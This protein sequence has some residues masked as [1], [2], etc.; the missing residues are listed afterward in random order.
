MADLT[1]SV[2]SMTQYYASDSASTSG[3]GSGNGTSSSIAATNA[4]NNAKSN[5]STPGGGTP[6]NGAGSSRSGSSYQYFGTTYGDVTTSTS[7]TSTSFNQASTPPYSAKAKCV[8]SR[9]SYIYQLKLNFTIPSDLTV[10]LI[11][12]AT[13]KITG[14]STQGNDKFRVIAPASSTEQTSYQKY[15]N[16]TILSNSIYEEA[17][18]SGSSATNYEIDVK[19]ILI[20]CINTGSSW[21]TLAIPE[22]KV[23]GDAHI[24]ITGTPIIEVNY[25]YTKCGAPTS[26]TFTQVVKPSGTLTISWS[27]ATSGIN[28]AISGY[29]VYYK[30]GSAPTTSSYDGT[31]SI[32]T[33]ATSG[34]KNFTISSTATRGSTFYAMVQTKGSSAAG[35]SFYS[36]WKSASGGK[37]NSLP[38]APLVS[39]D[40]GRIKSSG[41]TTITFTVT[42]GADNDSTQT[43]TLY[44]ATS[45]S[46]TKTSFT[47]PKSFTISTATT[48]YFWTYDGLEY[49]SSYTSKAITVNTAP[50]ITSVTMS[51]YNDITYTPSVRNGYVTNINGSAVVT[52][53][54]N[55]TLTYQWKLEVGS[56]VSAT[57]FDTST[58]IDTTASLSEID[59]TQYGANFNTAYRL[60]LKI[61]DDIGEFA[62]LRSTNV[63]AIPA[64]PTINTYNRKNDSNCSNTNN[65]HFEDGIRVIYGNSE[66]INT[67][68]IKQLLYSTSSDF[69][70]NSTE[71][72]NL[73]GDWWQDID[74]SSLSRGTPSYYFKVKYTC[75]SISADATSYTQGSTTLSTPYFVYTRALDLAPTITA[76]TQQ[77]GDII[78]PYTQSLINLTF[79]HGSNLSS[80]TANNDVRPYNSSNVKPT[81]IYSVK[82]IYGDNEISVPLGNNFSISSGIV[83]GSLD[84]GSMLSTSWKTL[85]GSSTSPNGTYSIT[86]KLIT[87]NSFGKSFNSTKS[88]NVSFIEGFIN[89]G[90]IAVILSMETADTPSYTNINTTTYTSSNR[91]PLFET[92]KLR[93]TISGVKAYAEQNIRINIRKTN[94]SGDILVYNNN[95]TASD[96]TSDNSSRTVWTLNTT[97]IIYT[98]PSITESA[99]AKFYIE[100]ILDN[101]QT[102]SLT[103]DICRYRRIQIS[104]IKPT[105]TEVTETANNSNIFTFNYQITDCGG[106]GSNNKQS[107][108]SSVKGRFLKCATINGSYTNVGSTNF[109]IG[110]STSEQEQ[111]NINDT[112]SPLNTDIIYFGIQ[113]NLIVDF[114]APNGSSPLPTGTSS[115]SIIFINLTTLYRAV[116][117][118]GY[119][120]NFFF[121]NQNNPKSG[122]TD[123]L[124]EIS[125]TNTRTKIYFGQQNDI[126]YFEIDEVNGDLKINCG[127]WS[128]S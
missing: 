24:D 78:K 125:P 102:T 99:D 85:I 23:T 61:T 101:G 45:A 116:P 49:S 72:I 17:V 69:P 36:D 96:W 95:L 77:S 43:K 54:S 40:K 108:F 62:E 84:I 14:T 67:G 28:N 120:K 118:L 38:N 89:S 11:D 117:N 119:G 74:L 8:K 105:I 86:L 48:Y 19:N 21:V 34:S 128:N 107:G 50:T 46:G 88:F 2:S 79:T 53:D 114:K 111:L 35:S 76:I 64:I 4:T 65:T 123:Q 18:P 126:T 63:F 6:D 68:A 91:Y 104:S 97:S 16:N 47:S 42:A 26:V 44:Y 124:L 82:F 13:L 71:T 127:S 20:Q 51:A 3:T 10:D 81:Y 56:G 30:I 87:T 39:V 9:K 33:T 70:S 32:S 37:V 113:V 122:R 1:I 5:T 93:F 29:N 12:S 41:S 55:A 22:N 109:T 100:F 121:L 66:N 103:S 92:Q 7:I 15:N 110:T 80:W 25:T 31:A 98:I 83:N 106:D 58:D 27:G 59:V 60:Y 57:T 112:S 73:T 90:S 75:G 115:Y 94:S 52:K